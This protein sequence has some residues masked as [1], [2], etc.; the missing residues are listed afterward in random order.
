MTL[1]PRSIV[2]VVCLDSS[3]DDGLSVLRLGASAPSVLF[4]G[5]THW[6]R[7]AQCGS[8]PLDV[9]FL[10]CLVYAT[11]WFLSCHTPS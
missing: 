10:L 11:V 2:L 5:L 4:A 7:K 1:L 9:F 6:L 3:N 8:V